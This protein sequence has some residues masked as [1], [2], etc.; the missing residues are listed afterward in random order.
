ML[1]GM[2]PFVGVTQFG[3]LFVPATFGIVSDDGSWVKSPRRSSAV[4]TS[5]PLRNVPTV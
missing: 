1:D 3:E 2:H 4:G 5:P